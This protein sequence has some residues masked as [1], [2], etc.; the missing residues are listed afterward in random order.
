MSIISANRKSNHPSKFKIIFNSCYTFYSSAVWKWKCFDLQMI[1]RNKRM[2]FLS[3]RTSCCNY[4]VFQSLLFFLFSYIVL[5]LYWLNVFNCPVMQLSWHHDLVIIIIW[6]L[7]LA[8]NLFTV[9]FTLSHALL[10]RNVAK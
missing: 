9:P 3:T 5:K 8:A 10:P 1:Q 7:V 2:K 4:L 6:R